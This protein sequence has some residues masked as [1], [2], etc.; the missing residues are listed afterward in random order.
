MHIAAQ[1]DQ[2]TIMAY[3]HEQG[4]S[5]AKVDHKGAT[6]LHWA[7]YLGCEVASTVLLSWKVPVNAV[8]IEGQTPLHLACVSGNCRIVRHLLLK[9]ARSDISD[10][11][12]RIPMDLAEENHFG[13][14]ITLLKKPGIL[15]LCGIKPSQRPVHNKRALLLLFVIIYCVGMSISI[16]WVGWFYFAYLLLG[17]L[18]LILFVIVCLK[19]PG[20]IQSESTS[21]LVTST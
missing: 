15:S 12:G 9:G 10:Q 19:N 4:Y 21:L 17:L 16:L 13:E 14:I 7:A 18:D 8:D 11:R 1:G 5:P 3:F 20:Y 2:L 6:P